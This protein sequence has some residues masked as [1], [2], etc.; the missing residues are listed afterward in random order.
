M[1]SFLHIKLKSI[2]LSILLLVI[3]AKPVCAQC[4]ESQA[5]QIDI[6]SGVD[7]NYRDINHRNLY[8]VLIN[9]TPAIKWNMGKGWQSSV[10]G[11]IP[12]VNNYGARYK[13]IRLNLATLS[14]EMYFGD[15][16]FLKAT[17]GWFTNERYGVDLKGTYIINSWLAIVAQ[18]GLTGFCSMAAGWEA[19]TAKRWSGLAGVDLYSYSLDTQ[20]RIRGGRYIYGDYGGSLELMRHF[21]HCSVGVYGEYSDAGGKNAGFKI[22]MMIPPYRRGRHKVN[23]R[24]TSNFRLTYNVDADFYSNKMYNTD[25]E[26]NEREGWFDRS[27]FK[28][29]CNTTKCDFNL[30]EK[31]K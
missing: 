14:K 4:L 23:V 8:E 13:N 20:V 26:E 25:P 6:F 18:T 11:L 15:R 24:P 29:G 2:I 1:K 28:W 3:Y 7:F 21:R 16:L 22:V 27:K 17:G 5:G 9:L 10:Q 31:V 19:S 30:K 12:I